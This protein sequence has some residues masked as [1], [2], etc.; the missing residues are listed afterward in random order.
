[1]LFELELDFG[2]KTEPHFLLLVRHLE[3]GCLAELKFVDEQSKKVYPL[4]LFGVE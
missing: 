3:F 1:M 2:L 4:E